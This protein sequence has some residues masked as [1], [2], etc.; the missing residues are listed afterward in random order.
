M[1]TQVIESR[2]T[3]EYDVLVAFLSSTFGPSSYE[4]VVSTQKF[5]RVKAASLADQS[6]DR[7][8]M[9]VKNGKSRCHESSLV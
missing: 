5:L 4:V 2:Y 8:P 6:S 9:K 7:Y 3:V 1:V